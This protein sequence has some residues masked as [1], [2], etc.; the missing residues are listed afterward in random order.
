VFDDP[1]SGSTTAIRRYSFDGQQCQTLVT[2]GFTGRLED[3]FNDRIYYVDIAVAYAP[4]RLN[5]VNLDGGDYRL[6]RDDAINIQHFAVY[7]EPAALALLAV[8]LGA[9][10]LKR[11]RKA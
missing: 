9:V 2:A 11:R 8:G 5:S 1:D 7:P 4:H 6:L 3:I 10:W